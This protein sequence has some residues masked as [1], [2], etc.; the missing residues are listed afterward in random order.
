[1]GNELTAYQKIRRQVLCGDCKSSKFMFWERSRQD[2]PNWTTEDAD[3][4]MIYL[5]RCEFFKFTVQDPRA[6]R[7]CEGHM[8]RKKKKAEQGEE[9]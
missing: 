7:K 6:L 3:S 9:Q 5:V 2:A 1:M 8:P 4:G